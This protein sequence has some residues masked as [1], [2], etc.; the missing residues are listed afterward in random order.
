MDLNLFPF[1]NLSNHELALLNNSDHNYPLSVI[2]KMLYNPF[3]YVSDNEHNNN[4]SISCNIKIPDSKYI[5]C[6]TFDLN[7]NYVNLFSFN[8]SSLARHLDGCIHQCINVINARFD[9]LG[10]C[11]TR[12][13]NAICN[14]YQI[15]GYNNYFNNKNTQGGG[16]ALY[17]RDTFQVKHLT[18]L[19]VQL[20]H[21]QSLFLQITHPYAFVVGMLYRP[22]NSNFEDFIS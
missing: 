9:V 12:L 22:P 7:S 13:D 17:V 16:V 21:I 14:L 19:S 20:P 8:I 1:H 3:Q 11:E 4:V 2:S 5:F 6:D 10:F 18:N 15:E